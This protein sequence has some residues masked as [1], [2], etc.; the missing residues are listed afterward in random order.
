M[1]QA[2]E[3]S[4]IAFVRSVLAASED[5]IKVISLDG[6]LT[7]MSEGG[8]RV[9]EVS[10]F[11]AIAGCPWPDFWKD[12]GNAE[13]RD[14]IA[15]AAAGKSSRFV[16]KADTMLGNARWW[17]VQVSPILDSSGAP[18]AILSVSRDITEL[19]LA[20][21]Q[22]ALLAQ[23]MNH[24]MRNVLTLVQAIVGQTLGGDGGSDHARSKILERIAAIGKAQD[25]LTQGSWTAASLERVIEGV[26]GTH[27][28]ISRF[29]LDGPDLDLDSHRALAM[30]LAINELTVNAIKHGALSVAEGHVNIVWSA[31]ADGN[32]EL[33]WTEHAGPALTAQPTRSGFGSTLLTRA[34]P[35]YFEGRTDIQYR[36]EGLVFRLTGKS[37][38]QAQ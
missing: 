4:D 30:A 27:S 33:T 16:G 28:E 37:A 26:I 35:A 15:S 6:N 29:R 31:D 17:D 24:R 14:A 21:Q 7:F 10:D 32:L 36:P 23:E 2:P 25:V 12:G 18:K 5:C 13:A 19:K 34:V 3:F 1:P 8:M 20:E 22:T 38:P 9:M 11:N